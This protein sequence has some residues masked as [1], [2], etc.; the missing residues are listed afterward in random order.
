ML[1]LNVGLKIGDIPVRSGERIGSMNMY[2]HMSGKA[3]LAAALLALGS[4]LPFGMAQGAV[5][6]VSL[7]DATN[8]GNF[9]AELTLEDTVV[10]TV[11]VTID[12]A[13]PIN[14]GLTQGD[15]LALFFDIADANFD[16]NTLTATNFD[17]AVITGG[18]TVF[19]APGGTSLGGNANVN[20]T[21]ITFDVGIETGQN[22]S[23]Q[24]FN[25]MVM[26][27]LMGT[28]FSTATF[29]T[30]FGLR[31]QS[32]SGAD[33]FAAGSSK[34]IGHPPTDVPEPATLALLGV[35]LAA[36]GLRSRR[37]KLQA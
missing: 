14:S 37:K 30:D 11:K 19:A 32:I 5:I 35:G 22:G 8:G 3:T 28:G 20:G 18:V 36:F 26:F 10:N 24:G 7:E 9:F 12:I 21:G 1:A 25:Q 23:S 4:V 34:L 27:D 13:D 6:G 17:P 15:I 29:G 2:M 33:L 31:V 16:P